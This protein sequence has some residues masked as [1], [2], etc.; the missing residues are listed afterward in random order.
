MS[1]CLVEN[2]ET[3][4]LVLAV[5]DTLPTPRAMLL[6]ADGE[7]VD[8]S[9]IVSVTMH[10]TDTEP[11][12]LVAPLYTPVTFSVV[13]IQVGDTPQ[14][15][16]AIPADKTTAAVKWLTKVVIVDGSGTYTRVTA[17]IAVADFDALWATPPAVAKLSPGFTHS[18]YVAAILSAE[19]AVRA[20]V[21]TTI[22]SPVSERVAYAVALMAS[23]ALTTPPEGVN[24]VSETMG[25]YSVRYATTAPGGLYISEDIAE[26]L[27]PWKPAMTSIYIGPDDAEVAALVTTEIVNP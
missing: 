23:R 22:A 5:D 6:G 24:I 7:P 17:P 3:Q 19:E 18:E 15:D 10:F 4:V 20:W 21:T 8:P 16:F 27:A 14:Y 26:L 1:D 25:D 2:V 13:G 11:E 9:S 12:S